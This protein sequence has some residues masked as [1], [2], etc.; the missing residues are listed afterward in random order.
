M[1]M[2]SAAAVWGFLRPSMG[3]ALHRVQCDEL[4]G[5]GDEAH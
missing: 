5:P 4:R 2:S 1:G 3:L